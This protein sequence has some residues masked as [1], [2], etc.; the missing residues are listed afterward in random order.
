MPS[1]AQVGAS[2]FYR[3]ERG[4]G[5]PEIVAAGGPESHHRDMGAAARHRQP[6]LEAAAGA[7][8]TTLAEGFSTSELLGVNGV[9]TDAWTGTHTP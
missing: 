2:S 8:P 4:G 9:N 1:G 3:Q 5:V 7:T 6:L